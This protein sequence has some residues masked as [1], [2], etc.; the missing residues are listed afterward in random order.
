M[1]STFK[2]LCDDVII[3][4]F[5]YFNIHEIFYSFCLLIPNLPSLL[6][7][8]RVQLHVR[9][10][11]TYFFRWILPHISL[12]QVVSLSIPTRPYNP[13]IFK[14]TNLRS[15]VLSD[16]DNPLK[17]FERNSDW[18]PYRLEYLSLSIRNPDVRNKSSDIGIRVLEHAFKLRGLKRFELHES[19]SSLRMVELFN[20][21]TFP[22]TF[23]SSDL[24]R[25]IITIYCH[26]LTL[27]SILSYLP[28]LI[29]FEFHSSF[30]Y[31]QNLSPELH[32]PFIR[33]LDL[34]IDCLQTIILNGIFRHAPNLRY[35]K[36]DC[37]VCPF[38]RYHI[39]LLQSKTWLQW[40]DTCTPR[41]R[42]LNVDIKFR[43]DDINETTVESIGKDLKRLNFEISACLDS[44]DRY[45]KMIGKYI[46]Q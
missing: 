28:R 41:L 26:W 5:S 18:P 29:Q 36:L 39:D 8:G 38:Q 25:V 46:K 3:E 40:I 32:F 21:L 13:S 15:L 33:K 35:F 2:H 16:V 37:S 27:Q 11:N 42:I 10:N 24:E 34:Q 9:S 6:K 23:Q 19:K 4:L 17:L 22:S 1:K 20:E 14:F 7:D 31:I 43:P 30:S 45:W 12:T 44:G